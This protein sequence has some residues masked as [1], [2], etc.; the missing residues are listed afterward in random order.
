MNDETHVRLIDTHTEGFEALAASIEGMTPEV[1]SPVCG[2]DPDT[3]R[4]I[5]PRD[6]WFL[7]RARIQPGDFFEATAER[8]TAQF[9]HVAQSD[10]ILDLFAR[11]EAD[12]LRW[13]A[14]SFGYGE[15]SRG[16]LTSGGSIANLAAICAAQHEP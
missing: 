15:E 10:S 16:I 7:D 3:I 5:T 4:W 11:L 9:R 13:L 2:V 8:F 14:S 12:V 6:S 1:M